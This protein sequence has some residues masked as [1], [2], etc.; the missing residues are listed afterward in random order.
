MSHQ[1]EPAVYHTKR[2]LKSVIS[3]MNFQLVIPKGSAVC[4]TKE[5][6]RQ[7]TCLDRQHSLKGRLFK[8]TLSY[9]NF[10]TFDYMMTHI[11]MIQIILNDLFIYPF[12]ILMNVRMQN[13]LSV[14]TRKYAQTHWA[15]SLVNAN[16]ATSWMEFFLFVLVSLPI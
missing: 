5:N 15:L 10:A 2:D 6:D 11:T 1:R 9:P 8:E 7:Q 12:Q 4:H 3:Q 13:Y 14:E 16:Q